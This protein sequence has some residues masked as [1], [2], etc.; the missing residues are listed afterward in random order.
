[1]VFTHVLYPTDLSEASLKAWPYAVAL[2]RGHQAQLTVLHVVP[3]FEPIS[4]PSDDV[5]SAYHTV[6]PPTPDDVRLEMQRAVTDVPLHGVEV[7]YLPHAGDPVR[8][9]ADQ[10]VSGS[11]DLIVMGTHG[12]SGVERLLIGSV[13]ERVLRL[14]PCPVLAIPPHVPG[15]GAAEAVFA[16]ILCP[17]DFSPASQ[18]ALG[19]AFAFARPAKG[20]V[21]VVHACE[22]ADEP[23]LH[24]HL[25]EV[26]RQALDVARDKLRT[27]L[28]DEPTTS[29]GIEQVVVLGRPGREILK[30]AS[31]QASDLIVMGAQ[32]RGGVG[33]AL[34][35]STTQDV[36]RGAVCPVLVVR[37]GAALSGEGPDKTAS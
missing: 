14:A 21:T 8:V 24:A 33:L 32:G 1:M 36:V 4:V 11:A 31:Q 7:R 15:V 37:I 25:G 9:I 34:V 20:S 16:R 10:A 35:G 30:I 13:T 17:V 29:G 19:F 3:T 2:A 18:E 26:Q 28:A 6:H 5:A 27:L 12:R 23:R 22:I